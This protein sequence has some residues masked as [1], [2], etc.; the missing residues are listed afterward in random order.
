MPATMT[1]MWWL[2]ILAAAITAFVIGGVWYSPAV[3][4][5]QWIALNGFTEQDLSRRSMGRVFALSFLLALVMAVN[6]ALF[7]GPSPSLG[8]CIGAGAAAG[9][10]WSAAGL[11]IIYLFEGRPF[12]LWLI[13]G[14]Y[15]ALTLTAIGG[16]LG[17]F[18][19]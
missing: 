6:L 16:V 5:R 11:G 10:G 9:I 2:A 1:A 4:G 19:R 12:T 15:Q 3:F 17:L 8:F 7:L 13:N 18:A 14:G